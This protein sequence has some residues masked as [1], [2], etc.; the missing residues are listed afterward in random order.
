MKQLR[1]L[2]RI[3]ILAT[4]LI[5]LSGLIPD[6][7]LTLLAELSGIK[8]QTINKLVGHKPIIV[9]LYYIVSLLAIGWLCYQ[10]RKLKKVSYRDHAR[11]AKSLGFRP[12]S[13]ISL[14]FIDREFRV[15][16]KRARALN[17][18]RVLGDDLNVIYEDNG[19]TASLERAISNSPSTREL[20]IRN[21]NGE[22]IIHPE[23]LIHY[24]DVKQKENKT[25]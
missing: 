19:V 15:I 2:S 24:D 11:A 7:H 6:H 17:I 21:K 8:Q 4:G 25:A 18:P 9:L 10:L 23:L 20:F 5:L 13:E 16:V 22:I 3:G 12:L 14:G 1:Q